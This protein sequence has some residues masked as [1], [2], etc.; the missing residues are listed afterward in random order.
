MW[1]A[2]T[3]FLNSSAKYVMDRKEWMGRLSALHHWP[4]CSGNKLKIRSWAEPLCTTTASVIWGMQYQPVENQ[5]PFALQPEDHLTVK[6]F[7]RVLLMSVPECV[8]DTLGTLCEEYTQG[9][10]F[11]DGPHWEHCCSLLTHMP[12]FL[13]VEMVAVELQWGLMHTQISLQTT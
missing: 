11:L 6:H 4:Q 2:L 9:S 8:W 13:P 10:L 12:A 3:F 7:L 1:L 5:P